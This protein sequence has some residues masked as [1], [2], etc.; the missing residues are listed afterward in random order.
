[1]TCHSGGTLDIYIEPVLPKL[2]ILILGRSTIA[3]ALA[4]LGKA[5]NYRVSVAAPGADREKFPDSIWCRRIWI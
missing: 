5:I 1:M 3:A 4:R 2:H